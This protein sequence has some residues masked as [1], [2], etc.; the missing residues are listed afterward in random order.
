MDYSRIDIL[1]EKSEEFDEFCHRKNLKKRVSQVAILSVMEGTAIGLP[2]YTFMNSDEPIM[3]VGT[4]LYGL[5]VGLLGL[6][7]P[8]LASEIT[9]DKIFEEAEKL[10]K[11]L[12]EEH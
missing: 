5:L 7:Y 3:R 9:D 11:I 6:Y 2:L 8:K 1:R 12:D 4:A 10:E